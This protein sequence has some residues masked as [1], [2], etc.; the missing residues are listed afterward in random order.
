MTQGN[1]EVLEFGLDAIGT[2]APWL[3]A[4]LQASGVRLHPK[5]ELALGLG[6]LEQL[7]SRIGDTLR[8]SSPAEAQMFY[9]R[10]T[11]VDFLSKALH[12]G[13]TKGLNGFA[14]H[15]GALG[16]GNP[17]LTGPSERT[18]GE[19]DSSWELL[20]ASLIASFSNDV[21]EVEP[22][23]ILCEFSGAR[24]G[25]AAKMLHSASRDKAPRHIVKGAKQLEKSSADHGFV[26]MNL[27]D[28]FPHA[29]MFWSFYTARLA[30]PDAALDIMH[31]WMNSFLIG[32]DLD[33]LVE[34]LQ[35]SSATKLN[36]LLFF[37]PTV[38][39]LE[40]SDPPVLPFYRFQVITIDG[41]RERAEAFEHALNRSCQDVLAY[42]PQ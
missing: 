10:S 7:R 22:P 11:G 34:R 25:I 17:V 15:F 37:V 20:L 12:R 41:R 38:L 39:Y 33:D 9:F 32:Y 4:E 42:R 1:A 2:C 30:S 13:K 36:S 5:S 29:R 27:V 28:V 16:S 19:R 14:K 18:S 3:R 35:H 31:E 21:C 6:E 24:I 8:F 40:A 26:V 23:D